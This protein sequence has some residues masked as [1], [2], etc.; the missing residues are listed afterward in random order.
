MRPKKCPLCQGD[1]RNQILVTRNIFGGKRRRSAFYRCRECD[2]H[3][4][5]PG[6]TPREETQFYKEE[7]EKFMTSR[8]GA[9]GG[10]ESAEKH[11]LANEATRLRR[12]RYVEPNLMNQGSVLEIGCSSGFM[13]LPLL[14][15][16]FPITAVEPSGKFSAFLKGKRIPVFGSLDQ[17]L[18]KKPALRF[19]FI[20][21]FFVLEHIRK[22]VPFLKNQLKLLRPQG[23]IVFEIPNVADPILSLF[24]IPAFDRFYW[25]VAHPWY[26]SE[27][28]L[29]F[30]LTQ[31]G[32]SFEIMREQR[33]DFSNHLIWA[34]D[35]KPGGTGMFSAV[36]GQEFDRIYKEKLIQS[37]Y[38]DT[39]VA[40]LKN[41]N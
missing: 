31:V 8:A 35:G 13:L 2:V 36:F 41:K 15:K 40:V 33:Y 19:D 26:F 30:L 7:F 18:K 3:Y 21:H 14:Q 39:L 16:G 28:S 22:P 27:K 20:M 25:S 23:R 38:C 37:G 24:R 17:L 11:L 5:Y 1:V 12:M 6:L 10:W 29:R 4:Q 9:S 34:R 32:C